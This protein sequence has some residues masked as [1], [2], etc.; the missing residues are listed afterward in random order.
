MRSAFSLLRRD[1]RPPPLLQLRLPRANATGQVL[2]SPSLQPRT[3]MEKAKA[4]RLPAQS[5]S[6]V[7]RRSPLLRRLRQILSPSAAAFVFSHSA[8]SLLLP[9]L[10]HFRPPACAAVRFAV[11]QPGDSGHFTQKNELSASLSG[12]AEWFIFGCV[13]KIS[14]RCTKQLMESRAMNT[15]TMTS[16][17]SYRCAA[18]NRHV[19]VTI[20][21][22]GQAA[23]GTPETCSG[24]GDCQCGVLR[25]VYGMSYEV[26]WKRCRFC[27]EQ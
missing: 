6:V 13:A 19:Q 20:T 1:P 10:C 2:Q 4:P 25:L 17:A 14:M 8:Q 15:Q 11:P 7:L 16:Q 9:S 24:I 5:R 23:C 18:A 22:R 21:Q 3:G 12:R 27:S 26:D